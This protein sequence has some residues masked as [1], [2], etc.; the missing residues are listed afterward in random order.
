MT[1][2]LLVSK[3]S[4][5]D[6]N[7]DSKG[8]DKTQGADAGRKMQIQSWCGGE[9]TPHT[10]HKAEPR[11]GPAAKQEKSLRAAHV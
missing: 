3:R 2:R 7:S 8:K 10:E 4:R 9:S 6:G 5:L 1:D 11:P